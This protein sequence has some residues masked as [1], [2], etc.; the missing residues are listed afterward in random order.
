MPGAEKMVMLADLARAI[1]GVCETGRVTEDESV[2]GGPE[3]GVPVAVPVL[4][5]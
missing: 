2:T 1:A 5:I 3:G 4:V